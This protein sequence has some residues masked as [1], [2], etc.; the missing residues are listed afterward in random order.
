MAGT[1]LM[2]MMCYCIV[3][4]ATI[5]KREIH[6][7]LYVDGHMFV[8]TVCVLCKDV[9]LICIVYVMLHHFN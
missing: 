6:L 9:I 4:E 7:Y 2:F 3:G 8:C 1:C 5:P